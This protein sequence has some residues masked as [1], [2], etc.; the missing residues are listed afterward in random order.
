MSCKFITGNRRSG[1]TTKLYEDIFSELNSENKNVILLLPEQSTF[2]HEKNIESQRKGRSLWNLEI[3]SFRRLAEKYVYQTL[4]SPLGQ[5]LFLYKILLNHKDEFKSFELKEISPG[6]VDSALATVAEASMNA[7]DCDMVNAKAEE[8]EKKDI[9]G[10]LDKKLQDIAVILKAIAHEEIGG[11]FNENLLLKAFADKIIADNPFENTTF[12]F[13]DFSDFT[14]AE[15]DI[16]KNLLQVN[17]SLEFAFLYQPQRP[18]FDKAKKAI[19]RLKSIAGETPVKTEDITLKPR[20]ADDALG[21]LE[22]YCQ[23]EE[24]NIFKGKT[25]AINLFSGTDT[26]VEIEA[27]AAEICNLREQGYDFKDISVN[28]RDISPYL[29]DI[30]EIFPLYN[31][32]YYLDDGVAMENSPGF[33]YAL[34]LLRLVAENWSFSAVFALIKSGLYPLN[35]EDCDNFENYCLSHGIKG[36]RFYQEEDWSYQNKDE[37]IEYINKVRREIANFLLPFAQ[38]IKKA[39]T[40][41]SYAVIIWDFLEKSN[42]IATLDTW[43]KAEEQQGHLLKATEIE[44]SIKQLG[45]LLDQMTLAFPQEKLKLKEFIEIFQMGCGVQKLRTIPQGVNEVEINIL[46]QSRPNST[47]IAFLAGVNEGRFPDYGSIDGFLNRNDREILSE[48]R[49]FWTRNKEFFYE[50]ENML[51]YQGVTQ[52]TEKLY[53]SYCNGGSDDLEGAV[54]SPSILIYMVKKL[55]PTVEHKE[56]TNNISVKN[57]PNMFWSGDRV[58]RALPLVLGDEPENSSWQEIADFLKSNEK[59]EKRTEFALSSLDYTGDAQKLSPQIADKYLKDSLYLNVSS[60]D[61]YRR[62]PFSYFAKYGLKLRE[63]R[64]LKF[65]APNL[66]SFYHEALR[67]LVEIMSERHIPWCSLGV[68]GPNIIVEIIDDMMKEFGEHNLFSPERGEFVGAQIKENLLFTIEIMAKQIENGDGFYPVRWEASFGPHEE[69]TAQSFTLGDKDKKLILTGQIDRVDLAQGKDG[70]YFRIIDYKSSDKDL[71]MDEIY[72]GLKLQLLIY[73]LIVEENGL[74]EVHEPL[75]PGG[76]FYL[77]TKDLMINTEGEIS[78][79]DL[80]KEIEKQTKIQGFIMGDNDVMALY[81]R[82]IKE[83]QLKKCDHD[84]LMEYLK[85]MIE[86][87]GTDIFNGIDEIKPYYRNNLQSCGFCQYEAVCGYDPKLHP[88]AE[89]LYSI[90]EEDATARIYHAVKGG[91]I[92]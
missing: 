61:I 59:T 44:A 47:K 66:G 7:L 14:V 49:E 81:P 15:Y 37:D 41:K 91:E 85:L 32:K 42:V 40:V 36:K 78:D 64:E 34:S 73:M 31:I 39:K 9:S 11:L 69:F 60:L 83:K 5:H 51:I 18:L 71:K 2:F 3:T 57:N 29:T 6:F 54:L 21:H 77:S 65:D 22:R 63:R 24:I 17:A 86:K 89:I 87:V 10:D 4:L 72:Y 46:G 53:L 28:F 90:K 62:C 48:D 30:K 84:T 79:E 58:I 25:D 56:I 23:G 67:R 70:K 80:A 16:I 8:M 52:P 68:E 20:I 27:I 75:L 13:D 35:E 82:D 33:V 76:I 74:K 19:H 55:F 45:E 50:N 26:A 1:K 88:K 12:F 43:K 38:R 92:K